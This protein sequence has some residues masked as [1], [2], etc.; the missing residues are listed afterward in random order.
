MSVIFSRPVWAR[1]VRC[2][3]VVLLLLTT[4]VVQAQQFDLFEIR[5][6]DLYWHNTY[7]YSGNADSLRREVVQMLKSKFF[8]FNVVR[9][10]TGYNGELRHYTIDCKRYGRRY[11]T[12]P[13]IYWEGEWT[14]KFIVEVAESGYRVTVYALYAEKLQKAPSYHRMAQMTGG[15]FID[16]VTRDDRSNFRKTE[17]GNVTLVS[18]SLRDAFDITKTVPPQGAD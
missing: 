4:S 5:D 11:A 6:N 15:R 17:L 2:L 1:F 18:A 16:Q 7:N 10:E 8:T 13:G 9:T 14:G 3:V 12:T